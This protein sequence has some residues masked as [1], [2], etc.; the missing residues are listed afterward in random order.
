LFFKALKQNL[1]LRNFVGSTANALQIQIWTALI[2]MLLLKWLHYMSQCR[3]SL[4]TL[5]ATL[6][7]NLFTYRD[8]QRFLDDPWE[9]PPEPDQ[10]TQTSFAW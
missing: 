9:P 7:L 4:S 10:P 6:R 2:T 3:W 5:A 1:T 8:L